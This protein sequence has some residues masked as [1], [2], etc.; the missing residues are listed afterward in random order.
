KVLTETGRGLKQSMSPTTPM[1]NTTTTANIKNA[2]KEA[3]AK[4]NQA[5]EAHRIA[6]ESGDKAQIETTYHELS[7]ALIR[8]NELGLF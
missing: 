4:F 8:C 5:C 7:Q 1:T 2:R 3:D 6:I